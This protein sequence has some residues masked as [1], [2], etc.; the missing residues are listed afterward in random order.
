MKFSLR[1]LLWLTVVVALVAA[2]WSDH[3]RQGTEIGKLNKFVDIYESQLLSGRT[4]GFVVPSGRLIPG[5]V[6]IEES[7]AA[8]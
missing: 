8:R 6:V 1:D 5:T 3:R 2:W 7:P 4:D